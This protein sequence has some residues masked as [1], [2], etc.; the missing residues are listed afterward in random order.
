MTNLEKMLSEKP[1]FRELLFIRGFL[2]STDGNIEMQG[3]PFYGKWTKKEIAEGIYAYTHPKQ[4]VYSVNSDGK[5]FFL[6]GHA[7]NP[8]TMEIDE[9]K[10]LYRIGSAYE[11]DEYID[12]IDE[13]T[14]IFV[15]G[16]VIDGKIS[17]IADPAG[18]QSACYGYVNDKFY[19]SSHPQLICDLCS[20]EMSDYVK[21][22]ISYKWYPR[23]KGPYLP[24]DLTPFDKI[25]RVVPNTSF[26]FEEGKISHK[27]FYPLKELHECKTDEEYIRVIEQ[28]AEIL[29]KNMQLV[30][31]KWNKPY[32]SLSGGIDSNTTFAA[33]N[34]VYDKIG[35]FSFISAEKETIDAD[36]AKIIAEKFNVDWDLYNIPESSEEISNYNEII[37]II[38]HNNG[39][40]AP[41]R[42]NEY[43]KRVYLLQN[44]KCDV[45]IK[46]WA[47]EI[48]RGYM[49]KHFG[50]KKF[51]KLSPK[52][53]RNIYKIFILN[54]SL[55]HKTDKVFEKYL[56]EFEYYSIPKQYTP[57][58]MFEYEVGTGSWCSLNI[59]EMKTYADFVII[60][61][62]RRLLDMLLSV[63]LEKRISDEHH[64]DMKKYLNKELYDM[65]IRVVNMY[66]TDFRAFMLNV[67]FTINSILPF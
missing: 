43:R 31:A 30:A 58:D 45:E 55:A 61:N 67:I 33:A 54:R 24:A 35:A 12:R 6:F 27:R 48:I 39:Y 29:K 59:S 63:P 17:F 5:T 42:A 51:P 56:N 1:E 26:V 14:G 34:G 66:E 8:F 57:S 60:Y 52:L 28:S 16:S 38:E 10:I 25:K 50:R 44:L 47:S 3:F 32:I 20:L 53:Y 64:L 15:L 41:G 9:E 2:L 21:E 23:V 37:S 19:I 4:H 65:G 62:N 46:S 18:M 11:T 7:Y 49:Y 13:L 40:I 22:L 36:A